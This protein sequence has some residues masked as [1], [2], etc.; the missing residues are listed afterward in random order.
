MRVE[1][2]GVAAATDA[3]KR[4]INKAPRASRRFI[5]AILLFFPRHG[6]EMCKGGRIARPEPEV[7]HFRGPGTWY[8]QTKMLAL[9]RRGRIPVKMLDGRIR[10]SGDAVRLFYDSLPDGYVRG[11]AP[12]NA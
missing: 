11:K 5:G 12:P 1:T 4:G 3:G 6:P 9:I 2:E 10:V 7:R 8:R